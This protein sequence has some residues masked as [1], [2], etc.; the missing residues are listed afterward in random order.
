MILNTLVKR[1]EHYTSEASK[2]VTFG[3]NKESKKNSTLIVSSNR[4]NYLYF[5]TNPK[6]LSFKCIPRI[7]K[8]LKWLINIAKS[9]YEKV[10]IRKRRL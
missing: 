9:D 5:Q 10:T 8:K 7:P 4:T 6:L 1:I 2:E 3:R